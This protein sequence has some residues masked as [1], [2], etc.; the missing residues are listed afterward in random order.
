[1]L[2]TSD[3]SIQLKYGSP[4]LYGSQTLDSGSSNLSFYQLLKDGFSN[5]TTS[6]PVSLRLIRTTSLIDLI[7][8]SMFSACYLV[9]STSTIK[10]LAVIIVETA[11][12]Q[13]LRLNSGQFNSTGKWNVINGTKYSW[14]AV[15][16]YPLMSQIIWHPSSKIAVYVFERMGSWA[17]YGG[18]AISINEE[19]DPNGC[20][21]T[22]AV[23][24]V[25]N[26][27]ISWQASRQYCVKRGGQLA[28]PTWIG[29][30]HSMAQKLTEIGASGQA[31]IGLRRSLLTTEWYWQSGRSFSFTN[32]ERGQPVSLEKGM[33]ASVRME[34][35]GNYTWSSVRCCSSLRPM[36]YIPPRYFSLTN[37]FA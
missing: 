14:A 24:D 5:I 16:L 2:L 22:P 35:N 18:P 8:V 36:C 34:P 1:M 37:P 9:H 4:P 27:S 17:P 10:S 29:A 32:W 3:Q 25:G 6:Q 21:V 33:C 13:D 15:D 31:W 11:G 26:L 23:L 20:M 28:G 12:V 30:H 7:P 19:P